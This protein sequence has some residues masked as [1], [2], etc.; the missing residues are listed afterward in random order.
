MPK[1]IN[2]SLRRVLKRAFALRAKGVSW[3]EIACVL[4][5]EGLRGSTGKFLTASSLRSHYA[6]KRDEIMADRSEHQEQSDRQEPSSQSDRSDHGERTAELPASWEARIKEIVHAEVQSMGIAQTG[7]DLDDDL[8]PAPERKGRGETRSYEKFSVTVDVNLA[9]LFRKEAK[10]RRLSVGRLMD[11]I[12]WSRYGKPD[13]SYP[14]PDD[15]DL[16]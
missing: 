13:L 11:A 4:E 14:A 9:R 7:E 12:L 15:I 5:N 2:L 10:R 1:P 16:A 6:R 8:P 3:N